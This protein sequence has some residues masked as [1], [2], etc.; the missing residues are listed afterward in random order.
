MFVTSHVRYRVIDLVKYKL[1]CY[2]IHSALFVSSPVCP[3][4]TV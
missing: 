2:L 4:H 3:I 1:K